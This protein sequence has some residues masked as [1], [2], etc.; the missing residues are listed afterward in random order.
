MPRASALRGRPRHGGARQLVQPD[1]VQHRR[2]AGLLVAAAPARLHQVAD[3]VRQLGD[4]R[5]ARRPG[6]GRGPRAGSSLPPASTSMFVRRLVSGVRSSCEASA[7]S[8]RCAS[9]DDCERR[10]HLV[11][12]RGQPADLVSPAPRSA[13][14]GRRSAVT[15]SAAS[16]SVAI[17]RAA[18][19]DTANP[20]AAASAIAGHAHQRPG[21]RRAG[22]A[23]G[24]S[25]SAAAPPAARSPPGER[26]ARGVDAQVDAGDGRVLV[27]RRVLAR[28]PRC[29][30]CG[31]RR[32]DRPPPRRRWID[33][34]RAEH[35]RV[36]GGAA[37]RRRRERHADV[38]AARSVTFA[39]RREPLQR[40]VDADERSCGAHDDERS[41]PSDQDAAI[42]TAAG[43]R[44]GQPSA[45]RHSLTSSS[46]SA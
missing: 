34:V 11:E 39:V 27:E 10:E 45:E 6:A 26:R 29:S 7:T 41:R 3:Q 15:C 40:R 8:R 23:P 42:A 24:R 17:G 20:S 16:V 43:G 32:R 22:P 2:G 33:A 37:E 30:A 19:R 44:G 4:L 38:A 18:V 13:G 12:A 1:V 35:L 25:R 21:S 9:C 14:R 36:S 31:R 46:R 5:T 28:R